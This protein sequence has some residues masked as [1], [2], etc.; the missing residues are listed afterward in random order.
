VTV[1][2]FARPSLAMAVIEVVER[3]REGCANVK[4]P[5]RSGI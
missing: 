1:K 3:G 5:E 4:R 2:A